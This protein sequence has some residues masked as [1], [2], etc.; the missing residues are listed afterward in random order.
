MEIMLV[1]VR[2]GG[3]DGGGGVSVCGGVYGLGEVVKNKLLLGSW[4]YADN[5]I[6][7]IQ[8]VLQWL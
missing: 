5:L 4:D 1:C 6:F 2:V 7:K 8:N 3:G